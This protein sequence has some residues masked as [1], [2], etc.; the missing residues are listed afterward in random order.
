MMRA[1]AK[2]SETSSVANVQSGTE[3]STTTMIMQSSVS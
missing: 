3:H 1:I 2:A